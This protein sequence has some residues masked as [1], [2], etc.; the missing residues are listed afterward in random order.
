MSIDRHTDVILD[1]EMFDA[2]AL[3]DRQETGPKQCKMPFRDAGCSGAN[4]AQEYEA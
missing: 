1:P 4:Q 3:K 2:Q